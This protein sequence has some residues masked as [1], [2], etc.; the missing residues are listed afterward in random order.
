M[1]YE[2]KRKIKHFFKERL[3]WLV[4]SGIFLAIG[5]TVML[6]GF[7][8]S[9]WSII[10]WLK[11]PWAVTSLIFIVT[12]SFLLLMAFLIKKQMEITK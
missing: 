5:L 8:M 12:G 11:S 1:K 4:G 9:G 10:A 6:I 2:T 7:Q 3:K